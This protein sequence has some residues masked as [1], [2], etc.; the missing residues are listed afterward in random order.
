MLCLYILR[1]GL[2]GGGGGEISFSF[3]ETVMI[4][5]FSHIFRHF[6]LNTKK[7]Y[8]HEFFNFLQHKEHSVLFSQII[9]HIR[10][11]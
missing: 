3:K 4:G 9:T 5:Y 7:V 11:I 1:S 10:V 2:G 6:C 8:K